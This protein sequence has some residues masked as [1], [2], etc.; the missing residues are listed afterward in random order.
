MRAVADRADVALGTL[1]RYFPSK[2]HLLVSALAYVLFAMQQL[3]RQFGAVELNVA[4]TALVIGSALLLLSAFWHQ[5]RRT[6]VQPLPES[7]R[8][9]LPILDRTAVSQPAA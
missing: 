3:F 7:L 4:L 9:R 5:A 1:Y 2:I 8:E 6:I